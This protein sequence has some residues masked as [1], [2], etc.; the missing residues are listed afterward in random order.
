MKR[1]SYTGLWVIVSGMALAFG[2]GGSTTNGTSQ[3]PDAG[4]DDAGDA[5]TGPTPL[6]RGVTITDIAVFQATKA[7]I[8]KGGTKLATPNAPVIAGRPGLV[9]VYVA[10]AD[11]WQPHDVTA[12]L[13]VMAADQTLASIDATITVNGPSNDSDKSTLF[14]FSLD[15]TQFTSAAT[16]SVEIRDPS[17]TPQPDDATGAWYPSDGTMDSLGAVDNTEVKIRFV[18][19]KYD[20]DSSGRLPDT[21]A[22]QIQRFHDTLYRMY[23]TS[24]VTVDV[25]AA[26]PWSTQIGPDGSG[27]DEVMQA[28]SDLRTSESAPNDVYYV[29]LFAPAPSLQAFCSQGCVLG[30]APL[31]TPADVASRMALVVDYSGQEPADTLNQELAHAMGREHAPCGSPAGPDPKYPYPQGKIGLLGYDI[32]NKDFINPNSLF[33]DFMSYCT[34]IWI[35]DYTYNGLW[36]R[37]KFV[38][39]A[40]REA[41]PTQ[42]YR[43]VS[44]ARDGSLKLGHVVQQSELPGGEVHAATFHA[45]DGRQLARANAYYFPFDTI[46][47]GYFLVPE[48]AVAS[49]TTMRLHA[50]PGA[51]AAISTLAR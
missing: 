46:A 45:Q 44:V 4:G 5:A 33:R 49:Y 50:V 22:T 41:G 13:K 35:S 43:F 28:V 23:P 7:F 19:L 2:C 47:G 14:E 36:K 32:L 40:H 30:V 27:W 3:A 9:R 37:M 15:A 6:A 26:V 1:N 17:A 25:H 31:A 38:N 12:T 39:A 20:A 48:N 16:F 8:V 29:G 24:K 18:P 42:P 10:P 51:S 34:P 11:G 21:G